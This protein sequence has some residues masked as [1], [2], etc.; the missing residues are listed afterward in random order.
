MP[1][2]G[3]NIYKRKDGRWEGRYIK[4]RTAAG[5]AVY[6]SVYARSYKDTRIK[7]QHAVQENGAS[8]T[9]G[10]CQAAEQ[11][12]FSR[13]AEEWFASVKPFLKESSYI[14]YWNLWKSY[15]CPK[16][17][18]LHL[19]EVS[20][21]ML[22]AYCMELRVSGGHKGMGLS[23]KTV[24]DTMSLLRSMFRFCSAKDIPIPCSIRAVPI[25]Q[26]VKEMRVFSLE[27]QRLLCSYIYS[28]LC[29]QNVGVLVCLFTGI[30]VG[31]LCALQ[32]E[33]I[34]FSEKTLYVHKTMQR[35]QIGNTGAGDRSARTKIIVTKPKSR[36]SIRTIPLPEK[37]VQILQSIEIT[38]DGYF[39]TGSNAKWVE[40]RTMQNH[41]KR[42]LKDCKLKEANYHALRHTFATRCIEKGFDVKSLSEILGHSSV[43]ITMDRY[44]H[45]SMQLKQENMQRLSE[46]L[47]LEHPAG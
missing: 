32:W 24:A 21:N 29:M 46:L 39:L 6:G 34:S 13:L 25:R 8:K 35:I 14:K 1:K 2:R 5:K 18:S 27:E 23:A 12:E 33:D 28:N 19:S 15:I 16:L 30:R 9:D 43:N 37:L 47:V 36:C 22:E 7:L 17:G 38:R 11:L 44:V 4:G 40:P 3:E 45:P 31:E 26:E 42:L 41:F 20:Q 10:A